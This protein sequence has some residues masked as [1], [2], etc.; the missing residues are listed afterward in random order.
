MTSTNFYTFTP[1]T[2]KFQTFLLKGLNHTFEEEEILE[3][4]SFKINNLKF[5]KVS[6]FST[7]RS[8]IE[9]KIITNILSTTIRR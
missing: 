4:N 8:I 3:L 9:K 7:K 6:R 1:K 2:D 5:Q